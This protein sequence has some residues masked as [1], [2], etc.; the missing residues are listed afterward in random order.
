MTASPTYSPRHLGIYTPGQGWRCYFRGQPVEDELLLAEITIRLDRKYERIASPR[1]ET[2]SAP[3]PI[4]VSVSLKMH[5]KCRDDNVLIIIEK[6]P[7]ECSA[8]GLMRQC[9]EKEQL[10]NRVEI[11]ESYIMHLSDDYWSWQDDELSVSI[12]RE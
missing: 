1:K 7:S 4:D 11:M 8:Y 6:L 10:L 3:P 9:I 5:M 2:P 12:C